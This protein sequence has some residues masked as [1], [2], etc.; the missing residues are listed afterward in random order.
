M[1]QTQI[2][3]EE[4]LREGG[5]ALRG[6]ERERARG[7]LA[8]AVRLNPRSE[9][10]WLL[11]AGA[12]TDPEQRR[13]CLE[14]VLRLNPE[15]AIARKALATLQIAAHQPPSTGSRPQAKAVGPPAAFAERQPP[16]E[17]RPRAGAPQVPPGGSLLGRLRQPEQSAALAPASAQPQSILPALPPAAPENA[18]PQPAPAARPSGNSELIELS[19]AGARRRGRERRLWMAALIVGVLMMLAG[20]GLGV[21]VLLAG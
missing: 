2:P 9:Q 17:H 8:Q 11:L 7:L 15:H 4:L 21:L 19:A 1:T 5:A 16:A 18:R 13:T 6:G 20:L 10:A 3:L 14:R 12:V